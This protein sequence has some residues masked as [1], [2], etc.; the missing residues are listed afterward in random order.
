MKKHR[1]LQLAGSVAFCHIG[2]R[3]GSKP[4]SECEIALIL[5]ETAGIH[6]PS[7]WKANKGMIV[8]HTEAYMLFHQI[9]FYS[10]VGVFGFNR[11]SKGHTATGSWPRC[12]HFLNLDL[13]IKWQTKRAR[14]WECKWQHSVSKWTCGE[15][16]VVP[17]VALKKAEKSAW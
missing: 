3:S 12:Q 7:A 10:L 8:F 15:I 2:W 16:I 11:H 17:D 5:L 1:A 14:L 13:P 9:T 4:S 6:T